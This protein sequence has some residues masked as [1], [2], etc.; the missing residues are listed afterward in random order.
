MNRQHIIRRTMRAI[1]A[2]ALIAAMPGNAQ[3]TTERYI[4]IG[5]S[6][7]VSYSYSYLGKIVE[8]DEAEHTITIEDEK[9]RHKMRVT[10]ATKIW[11]DRSKRRR[12]NTTGTYEDCEVG[13]TVE[14]MHLKDDSKTAAWIKIEAR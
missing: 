2:A 13:R 6:P 3:Q 12:E 10:E 5:E 4:P 11:I 1:L 9:G 8:V 14:V 7:G